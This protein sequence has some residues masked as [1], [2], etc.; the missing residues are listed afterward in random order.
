MESITVLCSYCGEENNTLRSF[1]VKCGY[2]VSAATIEDFTDSERKSVFHSLCNLFTEMKVEL[3]DEK[4]LSESILNAYPQLRQYLNYAWLRPLGG[5]WDAVVGTKLSQ[6]D[7]TGPSLDIGCGDGVFSSIF[8]G[9]EYDEKFDIGFGLKSKG[10]DL[11]D[12]YEKGL[13]QH[14]IRIHPNRRFDIGI[15]IKESLVEKAGE[16]GGY[17]TT[18]VDDGVYLKTIS[19]D[20]IGSIWSNVLKNFDNIEDALSNVYRV[21]KSD[22]FIVTQL[23]LPSML[24]NFYYYPQFVAE[25]DPDRKKHL[26]KMSRGES[27]YHPRYL[28]TEEWRELFIRQ[29]F[30]DVQ[31][32]GYVVNRYIQKMW[33]TGFRLFIRELADF[34]RFLSRVDALPIFKKSV[35]DWYI[36]QAIPLLNYEN[37]SENTDDFSFVLIKAIK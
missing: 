26:W 22:G 35:V 36:Q 24:N 11:F 6:I 16:S 9:T 30:R 8:L 19:S 31:V 20:S 14:V 21:L 34:S 4:Y 10:K 1:C 17:R 37:C 28:A 3:S 23:P 33:D 13:F 29:G 2:P 18:R 7:F 25:N 12:H 32:V 27:A 15:D 5:L